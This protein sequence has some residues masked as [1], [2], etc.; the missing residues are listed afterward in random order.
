[1]KLS[2]KILY[3]RRKAM[4]SQEAL[5]EKIGVSRQAISK[6]ETGEAQPEIGKLLLLAQT[7]GVT[8]DWL[9]SEDE[10]EESQPEPEPARPEHPYAPPYVQEEAAHNWV[11]SIP[12]VLGRLIRRYGWL[13]GVRMA[14]GGALFTGMGMLIKAMFGAFMT[15]S[16]SFSSTMQI[17]DEYGNTITDPDIIRAVGGALGSDFGP[18][19]G[20]FS[21]GFDSFRNIPQMMGNFV[22]AVGLIMLAGGIVL[23]VV[24][25]KQGEKGN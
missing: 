2:D 1:M 20:G 8:T 14:I 16:L 11:D 7:F 24:L 23:A 12:G 5:A 19:M 15:N 21:T 13:F 18:A 6:W 4:L 10:P 25:K 9:L 3:C 22:V 17:F